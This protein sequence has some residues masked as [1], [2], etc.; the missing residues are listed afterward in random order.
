MDLVKFNLITIIIS[1]L[2]AKI[3]CLNEKE[4][5]SVGVNVVRGRLGNHL[6]GYLTALGIQKQFGMKVH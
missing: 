6:W 5:I 3:N 4:E 1:L 2:S